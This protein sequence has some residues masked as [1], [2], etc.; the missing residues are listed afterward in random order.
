MPRILFIAAHRPNRSPSQRFRFEQYFSFLKENGFDYH[1]SYLISEKNDQLFYKP[2]SFHAKLYIFLRSALKRQMDVWHASDYDIVFI[3]REAFMTG[4]TFFARQIRKKKVKF[5]YDFDDAIWHLDVSDANK[6]L[7]WLKSPGKTVKLISMADLVIAGNNY[8]A[9]YAKHH[10][11]NVVIIPTTIDTNYHRKI[12]FSA[13]NKNKVCIGWT[14][15]ITTIKHFEH[16]VSFLKKIKEKY[17]DKIEIKVIGD[18]NYFNESI[19]VKGIEWNSE[20]EI[21]ELSKIDIGIMPLPD[22]EW[23]KGK[24]GLKGLSYMAM[25]IPAIMSPVGVN[26]D[27]IEDGINGFL[28]VS[29]NEW[30]EKLS[31]LIES[32]ELREKI[33][34]EAR[35]SVIE[36]YSV[37][38]QKQRYLDCFNALLKRT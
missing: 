8:L 9:D 24:C 37:E 22:D 3:Q 29:E 31:L 32:P 26:T 23:T 21:E 11:E 4:S 15:S 16:A 20:T 12:N 38:S 28:A 36:K 13:T 7:G 17:Q 2:G 19:D 33:G 34:K 30:I 14:G 5:V 10:N 27:I 6:K 25:E 35:K 1:L 18:P